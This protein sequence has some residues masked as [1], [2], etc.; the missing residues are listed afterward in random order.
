MLVREGLARYGADASVTLRA[1]GWARAMA[2]IHLDTGLG[3]HP[4]HARIGAATLA[5]L[6]EDLTG[7]R[8]PSTS[9]L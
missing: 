4:V 8:A 2:V 6:A 3:D 1:M 5:R 7:D 9:D